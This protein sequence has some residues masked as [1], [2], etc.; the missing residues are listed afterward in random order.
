MIG[1]SGNIAGQIIGAFTEGF[2]SLVTYIPQTI[3]TAFTNLFTDGNGSLSVVAYVFL[4]FGGVT[5]CLGLIYMVWRLISRKV[6][7]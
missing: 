5:L 3:A 6:G 2:G 4:V 1:S 7:A